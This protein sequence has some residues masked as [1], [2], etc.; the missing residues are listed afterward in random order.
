MAPSTVSISSIADF[1]E[2]TARKDEPLFEITLW[3]YRSLSNKGFVTTILILCMGFMVPLTAFF[4]TAIFWAVLVPIVLAVWGLWTAIQRTNTDATLTESLKIWPDLI[5]V[6]RKN[7]RS[8]D[9][10]WHAHP[11]F[12]QINMRENR[13]VENYITLS[14]GNREIELGAFLT[15]EERLDLFQTLDRELHKAKFPHL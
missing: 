14:G 12:V 13:E 2:V 10:F 7:P 8:E 3:P 11:S 15:P 6:Y 1:F 4:G 5:A 9:Q